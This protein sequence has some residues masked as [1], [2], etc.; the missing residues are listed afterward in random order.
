MTWPRK[1]TSLAP[2]RAIE[3]MQHRD[4]AL[5]PALR[6]DQQQPRSRVEPSLVGVKP[7]N[8]VLDPLVRNRPADE[9]Q[10]HP[11]V[12]EVA[13]MHVVGRAAQMR[14]IG[15]H[16]QHTRGRKAEGLELLAVEFRIAEADFAARGVQPELAPPEKALLHEQRMHVDEILRRRDVVIHE[17]HAIRQRVRDARRARADR[18]VVDQ[19]VV[20]MTRVRQ[21]P[22]IDG[23][24]LETRIGGLDEDLRLV[25]GAAQ[26]ALDAEHLVVRS[27]RRSRALPEPDE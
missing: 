9:Q 2:M 5:E 23:E 8:H 4:V 20:G 14:E 21:I 19:D 17:H 7:A 26:Y 12:V 22:V 16:R 6:S 3:L 10:I 27:H 15:H 1:C 24:V 11:I 25:P 18:K 13:R